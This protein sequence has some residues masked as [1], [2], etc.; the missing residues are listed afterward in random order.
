M[1]IKHF[2]LVPMCSM[3][4]PWVGN[5]SESV[6]TTPSEMLVTQCADLPTLLGT[7]NL[8]TVDKI[9]SAIKFIS[10]SITDVRIRPTC[11]ETS[12]RIH[13]GPTRL[14]RVNRWSGH[15]SMSAQRSYEVFGDNFSDTSMKLPFS[16]CRPLGMLPPVIFDDDSET[17]CMI[18]G[19]RN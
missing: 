1:H 7:P 6:G 14:P 8:C 15:A 19:K 10:S 12:T 18:R 11:P 9:G 2:L 5:D 13:V 4:P 3:T 17:R 16:S